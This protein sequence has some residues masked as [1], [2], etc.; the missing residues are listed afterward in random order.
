MVRDRK[1]QQDFLS[2]TID[3]RIAQAQALR[4]KSQL[5]VANKTQGIMDV[6]QDA[7]NAHCAAH[8]NQCLIHGHTHR[9]YDHST[10]ENCPTPRRLVLGDW[11]TDH[12]VFARHNGIELLL[13]TFNA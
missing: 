2:L 13:E 8:P 9:P 5:A 12:A 4:E 3:E 7:V 6:N 11:K 10:A 1:W